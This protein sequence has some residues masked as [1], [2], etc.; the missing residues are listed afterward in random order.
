MD[1]SLKPHHTFWPA[2][3]VILS[4]SAFLGMIWL[5]VDGQNTGMKA[6][7]PTVRHPNTNQATNTNINAAT[8]SNTNTSVPV[9]RYDAP[10]GPFSVTNSS[11]LAVAYKRSTD[12]LITRLAKVNAATGKI[13]ASASINAADLQKTLG[14]I[15]PPTISAIDFGRDGD[16]FV[17]KIDGKI[18]GS[19]TTGLY[20]A[21]IGDPAK[22]ETIVQYDTTHLYNHDIPN[23]ASFRYNAEENEVAFVVSGDQGT[24]NNDVNLILLGDIGRTVRTLK[25]YVMTPT[26]VGFPNAGQKLQVLYLD[27]YENNYAKST[28]KWYYDQIDIQSGEVTLT[29]LVV[30]E[31]KFDPA[32]QLYLSGD[33]ISPNNAVVA[34]SHYVDN[35]NVLAFRNLATGEVTD[36][37]LS[38]YWI[39]RYLWS[40]DSGKILLNKNDSATIFDLEKGDVGTISKL[41]GLVLW[42]P[43]SYIVYS[44][45]DNT[46]YSYNPTTKKS[47]TINDIKLYYDCGEMGCPNSANNIDWVNR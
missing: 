32:R 13:A 22:V 27:K 7:P 5:I 31:S 23:I 45:S 30:D 33:N 29:K 39:N 41:S 14:F 3:A 20:R 26:L 2:M 44:G 19:P 35:E 37:N 34:F 43:G 40:P 16:T 9:V 4:I 42:Y 46:L 47:V 28:R 10:V 11:T 18:A 24:E 38:N 1:T 36:K 6:N 25:Q 15:E 21:S 12:R 8:N 17:M